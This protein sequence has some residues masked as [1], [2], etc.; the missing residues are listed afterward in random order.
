[1]MKFRFLF[2]IVGSLFYTPSLLANTLQAPSLSTSFERV[3][4]KEFTSMTL[5]IMPH[6]GTQL[7]FPFTLDDPVLN[8][9]LKIDLT[10][11]AGF[12][13]PAAEASAQAALVNQNSITIIGNETSVPHLGTLFVNIGGYN[14][15]IALR[16][17]FDVRQISPT[18]IFEITEEERKHLI[19]H[20][21]D[22]YKAALKSEHDKAMAEIDDR[23]R[24]HALAFVGEVA[25][26]KPRS[27]SYKRTIEIPIAD[28]RII[29][30]ADRMINY[31][32][33][34]VLQFE[35]DNPNNRD[36]RVD[37][38]SFTAHDDQSVPHF[39]DGKALCPDVVPRG[40]TVKCTFTTTSTLVR[41]A[42]VFELTLGTD[43][44][45]ESVKW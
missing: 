4:L 26:S 11:K 7:I 19:N 32:S 18:V 40:R 45:T 44:G 33:F 39:V 24:Q 22:R 25:T 20:S 1:M 3:Q 31:D 14:L 13:I 16:T 17:V 36:V 21:I 37:S 29:F 42:N 41:T 30:Y 23:S 35:L 5:N 38:I 34:S 43:I 12:S 6:I 2:V 8:P 15:S 10:N 9:A 28:S 27:R